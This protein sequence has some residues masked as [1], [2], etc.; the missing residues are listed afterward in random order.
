MMPLFPDEERPLK[1]KLNNTQGI[2]LA[3]K[4][5]QNSANNI[6]DKSNP[7]L[8][9]IVAQLQN[10][11]DI[12]GTKQDLSKRLT[13]ITKAMENNNMSKNRKLRGNLQQALKLAE[14][15]L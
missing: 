6:N 10:K 13:K 12:T 7:T 8:P 11:A 2:S 9:N 14:K 3:K 15:I 1:R 5:K 4:I